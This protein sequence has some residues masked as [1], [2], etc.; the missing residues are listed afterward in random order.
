MLKIEYNDIILGIGRVMK[1]KKL[2]KNTNIDYLSVLLNYIGNLFFSFCLVIALALIIFSSVTVECTV[3]GASMR[4][5]YNN[6]PRK[7][8]DVVYVNVYDHDYEVGDIIVIKVEA[9]DPIIKRVVALAGDKVD[10]IKTDIGYNLEIN[11]K[12]IDEDYLEI[13]TQAESQKK[14]GLFF[15]F[16]R[17]EALREARPVLFDDAGKY[18]VK[19]NQ[20][21]ALG[22]N[23][24]VSKDSTFYGAFDKS[25]IMGI[26]ERTRFA[27][28]S[29]FDFYVDYIFKGQF[30]ESI[31]NCF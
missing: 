10:I 19:E 2:L 5:L 15:S 16:E 7:G 26:V 12:L 1:F 11:G 3:L 23:R 14:N 22:D 27:D 21:F 25:N 30:F 18:V 8:N 9:G 28:M 13:D 29:E 6:D 24:H 20:V 17:L 4:P 31:A